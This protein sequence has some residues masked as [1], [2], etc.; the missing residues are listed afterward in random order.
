[1]QLFLLNIED[2]ELSQRKCKALA[3]RKKCMVYVAYCS[4]SFSFLELFYYTAMSHYAA[5]RYAFCV[6]LLGVRFTV[7][8]MHY[9]E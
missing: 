8:N 1:M 7:K 3:F 4:Q 9:T 2:E 6:A 5:N